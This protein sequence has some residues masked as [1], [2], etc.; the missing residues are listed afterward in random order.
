VWRELGDARLWLGYYDQSEHAYRR[1]ASIVVEDPLAWARNMEK[2]ARVVGEFERRYR[3]SIRLLHHAL[4]RLEGE[5]G[6]E[7]DAVKVQLLAREA[8]IRAR[9]GRYGDVLSLCSQVIERA[10]PIGEQRAIGQAYTLTGE[11]L[12]FLGRIEE[13]KQFALALEIFE[14]LGDRPAIGAA[15]RN[16]GVLAHFECRWDDAVGLFRR[17]AEVALASGDIAGAAIS[18]M[19]VG[20]VYGNQGRLEEAE[21]SLRRARRTFEGLGYAT[22]ELAA[23]I[24]LGRV[25]A[26]LG[27]DAE[28]VALLS[29]AIE[30]EDATGGPL[31]GIEARGFLAEAHV[32]ADR[33]AAAL[34]VVASA[35]ARAGA[36]LEG[37]PA[38]VLLDRVEVSALAVMG[39]REGL[40][41][42]IDRALPL[43]RAAGTYLDLVLLLV[44]RSSIAG[45]AEPPE[46]VDERERLI[47][48][49]GIV[50]FP[51]L[52]PLL[53]EKGSPLVT[54]G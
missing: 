19:N 42:R 36:A 41:E 5:T 26:E 24:Q 25:V 44:L 2:R 48:Q 52:R 9:Q 45:G 34:E 37:T 43:A 39:E 23:V 53:S 14:A 7:A 35:R 10:Q 11:A 27:S 32:L 54:D 20:E 4:A 21:A 1:A 30:M 8:E 13:A 28:A 18:E 3:S 6:S 46:L 15:L 49:L 51:A 17:S 33:P 40:V 22:L 47:D 50:A 12:L 38:G 16:L 31:A 29:G